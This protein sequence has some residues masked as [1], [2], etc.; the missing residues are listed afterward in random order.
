[1]Y[2]TLG[3]FARAPALCVV[4]VRT[5]NNAKETRPGTD[6]QS[7]QKFTQERITIKILGT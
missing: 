7:N 4:M 3:R 2:E 1:M 6:V 5:V